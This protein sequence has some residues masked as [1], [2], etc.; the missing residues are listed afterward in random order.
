MI[1]PDLIVEV[2]SPNERAGDV[3]TKVGEYLEAGV[4]LVWVAYPDTKS[5]HVHTH[6]GSGVILGPKATIDG[7]D[8]L[9]GFSALVAALF[10]NY[11]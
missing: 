1:P 11:D 7:G 8:V 4:R 10:P 3:E 6:A 9:P 2:V 5:V